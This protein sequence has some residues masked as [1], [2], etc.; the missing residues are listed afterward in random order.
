MPLIQYSSVDLQVCYPVFSHAQITEV[1]PLMHPTPPASIHCRRPGFRCRDRKIRQAARDREGKEFHAH[2]HASSLNPSPNTPLSLLKPPFC[3]I[4]QSTVPLGLR[5]R[6]SRG[7]R[8]SS[9]FIKFPTP[10]SPH[11]SR[12]CIT[13]ISTHS[14]LRLHTNS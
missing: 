12:C 13:A 2:H 10:S 4:G 7:R 11:H 9:A 6:T 3:S 8:T 1:S 14:R 5:V